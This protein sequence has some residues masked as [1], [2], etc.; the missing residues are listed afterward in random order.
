MLRAVI[1]PPRSDAMTGP[2]PLLLA[3]QIIS[4]SYSGAFMGTVRPLPIFA[5]W[6]RSS[7][8]ELAL[9]IASVTMSQ[10]RLAISPARRPAF[11]DSKTIT[12]FRYGLRVVLAKNRRSST[13][14]SE[15]IFACLLAISSIQIVA[16]SDFRP[17]LN[18]R[19]GNKCMRQTV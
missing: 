13:C 7:I 4:D 9:P 3:R 5:A 16:S 18:A 14:C 8:R 10:V 2:L 11:N 19:N 12:R 1:L 15:R 17:T 6:S